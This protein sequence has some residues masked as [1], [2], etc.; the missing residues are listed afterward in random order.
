MVLSERVS[1]ISYAI[2]EIA[3]VANEVA[4]SGKK[5]YHLNIGDPVIFDFNTPRYI[6]QAL[7]DASFAGKNY[8]VDSLGVPEL[9]EA[10]SQSLKLKNNLEI[11]QD[12][13]LVTSGVTEA[14]FF[15]IA[16][17]IENR[18]EL[19]IPGPSYPLYINYT[20][21]FDGVPVEYELDEQDSQP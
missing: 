17:L 7:A 5:I 15:I 14:I 2:R 4:K 18:K 10:I 19:L 6:S 20:N 13:I 1:K 21:F 3:A 12:D 16:G 11:D 8:Y 9:R